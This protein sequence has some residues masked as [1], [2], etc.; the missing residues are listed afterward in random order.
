MGCAS[1]KNGEK[2]RMK[3]DGLSAAVSEFVKTVGGEDIPESNTARC[4][5]FLFRGEGVIAELKTLEEEAVREHSL[6]LQA[7]VH[8]WM[9]RGRV[10][11]YGRTTL[12][13]Q[14]MPADCQTEWLNILQPPVE[15]IVR[16]ANRQI[17]STKEIQELTTA[18]GL[19]LIS[20]EG[21]LLYETPADYLSVVSRVLQKKTEHGDLR[22]ADINAVVYLSIRAVRNGMLPVW[23]AGFCD[24]ADQQLREFVNSLERQWFTYLSRG[25]LIFEKKSP[26]GGY[27]PVR[28]E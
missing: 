4:A 22:F 25:R 9:R 28:R 11:V 15:N 21:N 27:L 6:K 12:E 18:K 2:E 19:L 10:I 17:R 5:D 14:K 13:L 23:Q 24:M 8:E 1:R 7:R 20:N 26:D 16:D 3:I